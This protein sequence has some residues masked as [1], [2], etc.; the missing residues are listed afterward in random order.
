[1]SGSGN[2]NVEDHAVTGSAA[3]IG[4]EKGTK[5]GGGTVGD[6]MKSRLLF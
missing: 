1:M 5:K 3:G 2:V 4:T 6:Q